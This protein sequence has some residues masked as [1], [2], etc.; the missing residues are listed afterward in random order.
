MEEPRD[1]L[2]VVIPVIVA[3]LLLPLFAGFSFGGSAAL[4]PQQG[5]QDISDKIVGQPQ[6]VDVAATTGY[7]LRFDGNDHV[8]I[9]SQNFS[10]GSWTVCAAAELHPETNRNATYDVYAWGNGSLLLQYDAGQW[11]AY[12]ENASGADAKATIDAPSPSDSLTPVCS[13]YNE[14]ENELVVVRDGTVSDPAALDTST[15][16][17]NLSLPWNGTLDEVR[18]FD[19]AVNNTTLDAYAADPIAPLPNTNRS[20]RYMFDE[21]EGSTT[22]AYFIGGSVNIDGASWTDGVAKPGLDEGTDYEIER[23]PLSLVIPAGSY[24]IG[25]PVVYLSWLSLPF[26]IPL[27][28]YITALLGALIIVHIA[29]KFDL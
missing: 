22:K 14:T 1:I 15:T 19:D 25:A 24:L 6:S 18:G 28:S 5:T 13:R 20:S 12:Y 10:D 7:G 27:V 29:S 26:D 23:N 16:S 17:R 3:V 8:D 21:G 9:Q 2:K 4:D 11:S